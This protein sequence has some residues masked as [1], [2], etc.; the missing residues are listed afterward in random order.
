MKIVIDARLM[1]ETGVGRYIRNLV[2]KL[3]VFD[4]ENTYVLLLNDTAYDSFIPPNTRWQKRKVNLHWHTLKEQLVIP[5]ILWQERPDIVHIPYFN[6]PILYLGKFIVTIH[7]LTILHTHTGKASTL[8]YWKYLIRKIAYRVILWISV[9][10]A[11]HI[12]TVS[13]TVKKDILTHFNIAQE[14]ITV[15]YEGIDDAFL[16]TDSAAS[17]K[18]IIKEKYFLYVGNVYPHKNVETLLEAFRLFISKY[19]TP[20]TLVFVGPN[21]YFYARLKLLIT[22]LSM[23]AHIDI[24]HAVSDTMLGSLYKYAEALIFPSRMEGFGLPALEALAHGC[25]VIASDIPVFHEILGSHAYFCDTTSA[26]SLSR[27]MNE[28]LHRSKNTGKLAPSLIQF[29]SKFSWDNMAK[30]TARIYKKVHEKR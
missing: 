20:I 21:D 6:V 26:E 18:R 22:S 23:D 25:P 28:Q 10:R 15:T 11:C 3:R 16:Q 12:L 19:D 29:L 8:P 24:R 7:D 17:Q 27:A 1:N 5:W 14:S 9:H 4:T 13:Q 2:Q 30:E